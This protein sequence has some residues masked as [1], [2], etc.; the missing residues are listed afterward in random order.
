DPSLPVLGGSFTVEG[1]FNLATSQP[2]GNLALLT[3]LS[4]PQNGVG[5]N[6]V[7]VQ[8]YCRSS[9]G[10][11]FAQ[12]GPWPNGTI[13]GPVLIS[14]ANFMNGDWFHLAIVAS[15]STFTV[16]VNGAHAGVSFSLPSPVPGNPGWALAVAGV[17]SPWLTTGLLNCEVAHVAVYP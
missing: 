3:V 16:Y 7:V 12:A 4:A 15:S 5:A 13:N 1:W 8:V 11:L 14:G 10:F 2:T 6:A 9:D 17:A